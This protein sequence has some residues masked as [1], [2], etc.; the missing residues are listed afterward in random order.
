MLPRSVFLRAD[1][2]C[3]FQVQV[4]YQISTS[5]R[6]W[7]VQTY[8]S[9]KTLGLQLFA[10]HSPLADNVIWGMLQNNAFSLVAQS[11]LT[12]CN[13][14]YCSTSDFPLH[15][16]FLEFAQTH[17]HRIGDAIQL[18]HPLSSPFPPAFNLSQHQGLFHW[19]SSLHQVV[20][21]LEFQNQH[22]S[23]QWTLRTDIL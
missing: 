18:S 10:D 6:N 12:L 3:R 17:V 8:S 15:H 1:Y 16:Q 22:Q 9:S 21:I 7:L 23:F 4:L 14:M 2:E 19:V 20:K 13:H 5:K 11:C